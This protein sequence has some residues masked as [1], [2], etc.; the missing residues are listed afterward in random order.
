MAFLDLIQEGN[1]GLIRA[2]ERFDHT[3]GYKFTTYATWWIRQAITRAMIDRA[4]IIR[5]PV[6][7]VERVNQ[8][9][10][11]R[12]RLAAELAREPTVAEIAEALRVPEYAVIELISYDHQPI[13]LDRPGGD[14]RPLTD[15]LASRRESLTKAV[16][17]GSLSAGPLLGLPPLPAGD[18]WVDA[19][20]LSMIINVEPKT[21]TSW[22]SRERPVDNPFPVP[23]RLLYR[24]YW[25]L[26]D[27]GAWVDVER[28]LGRDRSVL[29]EET[30]FAELVS[31]LE[32][33]EPLD[34][35]GG[36]SLLRDEIEEVLQSFSQRERAVVRMRFGLD[37]GRRHTLDE[38]RRASGFSR[39][40]VRRIE[41][42]MLR[43][44]RDVSHH[45]PIAGAGAA[46]R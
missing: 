12:R 10:E 3:K 23:L 20:G 37:D 2:V 40:Q 32:P 4:D 13:P 6:H 29:R 31:R 34:D 17:G 38:I 35:T 14:A 42:L 33:Q 43:R 15:G 18:A 30:A 41:Q 26:N 11:A 5:I 25:R 9:I 46:R 7:M 22:L 1:L 28:Q 36:G 45:P 16:A 39:E 8:M 44:L 24:N 21:V 27:I 19:A